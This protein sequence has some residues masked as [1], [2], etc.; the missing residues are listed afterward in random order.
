MEPRDRAGATL[1]APPVSARR[2]TTFRLA[3]SCAL[4]VGLAFLQSPGLLVADTKFDLVADPG[5]FLGRAL[6]LW[7]AEGAFGQLQNQAYGYLWPMGP[8]FLLGDLAGMP[9]WVVQRLWLALVLCVAFL[10]AA[11]VVRALGVRSDLAVLVAGFAYATSPRMLTTLGPISIEAWPSAVAPWV[12][13]PLVVGATRGS[14]RRAAMLSGLAVAMV[15]GVNAAATFA[16]LPLGVVWLL[17]RQPGPRRRALMLWWPVFTALGTLWWLVPLFV[18]GAY[19]PPFLDYIESASVTTFPTTL[20]DALRGTSNWVPYVSP[21]WQGGF[22][23]IS[24]FYLAL[25]S[26]LVLALGLLGLVLRSQPHR[27][28]LVVSVLVGLLMVTMGHTGAV[29][30]WLADPLAGALDGALAPLRNVHKFDPIVRLPLVVGLAWAVEAA[31]RSV[32]STTLRVGDRELRPRAFHTVGVLALVGVVG[33]ALPLVSN[34]VAPTPPVIEVPPYWTQTASWLDERGDDGGVSLLLPGSG[35]ADYQWGSPRDEPLQYLGTAPWAVR[36]AVPLTPPGNIRMLDAIE[37]DVTQGVGGDGLAPYLARAGVRYLV[38]R[39]DLAPSADRADLALVHQALASSPDI[40][41][42]ETFGPE[43]GGDAHLDTDDGRV[44]VDGGWQTR[45]RAIEVFEVGRDDGEAM[46]STRSE[47]RLPVVVG[48][49]EDLLDLAG[50][51]LVGSE[52]TRL[53]TDVASG[54]V[55]LGPV[56]LTDGMLDRERTFGRVHDGYAA[57]RT[58]GDVP[59][60]G[61]PTSDYLLDDDDT[62][63]TTARLDGA[64]ALTAS[65]STS[66]VDTPSGTRPGTLPYAAVDR[67]PVSEW[68]SSPAATDP[69]WWQVDLEEPRVVREVTVTLG[70]AGA[71]RERLRVVTEAGTSDLVDLTRGETRTVALPAGGPTGWVRVETAGSVGSLALAEVEVPGVDVRRSLVLPELPDDWAA[72]DAVL[73]RALRDGRTGCVVVDDRTPCLE[74]RARASEEPLDVSRVVRLPAA[75]SYGATLLAS[76]RPGAALD[77]IVQE[78]LAV[79]VTGS[80]TAVDDT[81]ASALAAVD[82]DPGTAWVPALEDPRPR[83]SLRWLGERTLTGLSLDVDEDAPVAR[84]TEV[85]VAWPGGSLTAPVGERGTVRWDEPVTTDQLSIEILREDETASIDARGAVVELPA[86]I[87]EL[88]LSGGPDL[89]PVELSDAP[90]VQAC[91]TG[92]TVEVGG[93]ARETAL[94]A[95]AAQLQ[96]MATV[97]AR[98]CGA[99]EVELAAGEN[100]VRLLAS[101]AAVPVSLA[102]RRPSVGGMPGTPVDLA[103]TGALGDEVVP[104]EDARTLVLRRNVNPGWEATQ[105][106]ATLR[107]LVIDGW[108]QGFALDDTEPV[109]IGF[110]PDTPYRVGLG[111]GL[112]LLVGLVLLLLVPGRRWPGADAPA[113]GGASLP[114]GVLLGAGLGV[115]GLLGGTAGVVCALAG[116]ALGLV[117]ATRRTE[118]AVLLVAGLP[119]VASLAYV[120]RPWTSPD[121]WAGTWAWPHYLVLVALFAAVLLVA[122]P[123]TSLR[124]RSAGTST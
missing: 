77:A 112:V 15:G 75:A 65:S 99:P 48:G 119:L 14:P 8:F 85:R 28:F 114:A 97:P 5:G 21:S 70:E 50:A 96:A 118:D 82:G 6:H 26:G 17:T 18:M 51:D 69:P 67:D 79:N 95:S 23:V 31:A 43:V 47:E 16:V 38:V 120:L 56:V 27:L 9:G 34:R 81:R 76:P 124:R 53:A 41:L 91:G 123:R 19:S 32:G 40:E 86:G 44:L 33:A 42:V 60:S 71:D 105:D 20:F 30:G 66:D 122:G 121:G 39:N 109:A 3:A 54:G 92:P 87:S 80:S 84:P 113:L 100:E 73:L 13:L 11:L 72:P 117:C 107:P 10:G 4:L 35:F 108:Q 90:V 57:V 110:A 37:T 102:L 45:Y 83:L 89:T 29:Q 103:A 93:E 7:D 12:L 88:S 61:N 49:P 52:P 2:R 64:A 46:T 22:E 68:V 63:L 111:G 101:D 58:P 59:R 106:G 78:G 36:N 24:Q 115:A 55:P 74:S 1:T 116:Y 94:V 98:L 25:N 104:D 62:W